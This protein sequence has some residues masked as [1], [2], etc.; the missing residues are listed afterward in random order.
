MLHGRPHLGS[1]PGDVRSGRGHQLGGLPRNRP[2]AGH[3][4]AWVKAVDCGQ[5]LEQLTG[6][7]V[8]HHC[9]PVLDQQIAGKQHPLLREPHHEI[10]SGVSGTRVTDDDGALP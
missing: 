4:H 3:D 5:C 7:S 10:S 6:I 8:H 1:K 9:H 2:V